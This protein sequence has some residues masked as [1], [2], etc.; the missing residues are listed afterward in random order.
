MKKPVII[1]IIAAIIVIVFLFFTIDYILDTLEIVGISVGG[2][3][4]SRSAG[5]A[6]KSEMM[7]ESY[8]A[9]D[10]VKTSAPMLRKQI[11]TVNMNLEVQKV[12]QA[13]SYVKDAAASLGGYILN[14]SSYKSG[15]GKSGYVTVKIPPNQLDAFTERVKKIGTVVSESLSGE[16]ITEKY[17]DITTRIANKKELEKRLLAL[18][19]KSGKVSDLLDVEKEIG[20]VREEI[21][22]MQGS[23][24]YY[25]SLVDMATVN[26]SLFE[27]TSSVPHQRGLWY[28]IKNGIMKGVQLLVLSISLIIILVIVILPWVLLYYLIALIWK[29]FKK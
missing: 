23:I 12:D 21:E 9:S 10:S 15:G 13:I 5:Q 1:S 27:P 7:V 8:E 29:R 20:R 2:S 28:I 22:R 3:A 26:I 4:P 14:S 18:L 11:F 19:Y 17:Y 6:K 24:K 16:D 25:D